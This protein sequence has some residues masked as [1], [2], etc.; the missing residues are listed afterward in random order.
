M[1]WQGDFQLNISSMVW[2][3]KEL[4]RPDMALPDKEM[5]KLNRLAW[6]GLTRLNRP[7]KGNV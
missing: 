3:D 2:P 6:Y 4:N 5:N 1:A 7:G